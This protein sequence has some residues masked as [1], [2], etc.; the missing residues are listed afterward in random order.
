[1]N[2]SMI[3]LFL[4]CY[5]APGFAA[6]DTSSFTALFEQAQFWQ[7]KNRNDLAKDALQR[8]LN[9]D[10]QILDSAHKVQG[11]FSF[12]SPV[13][14]DRVVVLLTAEKSKQL[15]QLL[16]S[17]AKPLVSSQVHGDMALL[18]SQGHVRSARAGELVASGD[19]PW[20]MEIRWFFGQHVVFMVIGLALAAFLGALILF[21]LLSA[22]AQNRLK[23]GSGNNE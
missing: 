1:M 2:K 17:L 22:R 6:D 23:T 13:D 7:E 10:P 3:A 15:P 4:A 19:M 14:S 18:D 11:L 21:P 12:V 5:L 16:H 20:H 8:I 9:A